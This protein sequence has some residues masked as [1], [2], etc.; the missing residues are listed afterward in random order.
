MLGDAKTIQHYIDAERERC[1]A[2]IRLLRDE[3]DF[4]LYCIEAPVY[5]TEDMADHRQRFAEFTPAADAAT[6]D[7]EDLM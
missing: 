3:T 2:L 5:P 6:D 1:S 7:V 4:L